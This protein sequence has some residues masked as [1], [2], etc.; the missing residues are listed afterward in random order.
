LT[1]SASQPQPQPL[2]I[3]LPRPV[4]AVI[5]NGQPDEAALDGSA[6]TLDLDQGRL[7]ELSF[8]LK[9]PG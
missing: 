3:S 9:S 5:R 6:V 4:E 2:K 8:I 7:V 1:I